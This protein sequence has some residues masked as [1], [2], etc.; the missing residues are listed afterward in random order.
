MKISGGAWNRSLRIVLATAGISL[1]SACQAIFTFSPLAFLQRNPENLPLEQ[2][3][4]YGRNA[5]AS[6]DLQTMRTAYDS[7]Q[8]IE[9]VDALY[10]S[11]E[12]AAELSGVP[13]I[14]LG[15]AG[16]SGDQLYL[17]EGNLSDL[18][19]YLSTF[20]ADPALLMEAADLFSSSLS[21]GQTLQPLDYLYGSLG[22][23]LTAAQQPDGSL[24]FST[25]TDPG[26]VA[27]LPDAIA[28][29][30]LGIAALPPQPANDPI[31]VF[32][33]TFSKYL[34]SL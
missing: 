22:L 24:D 3:I 12:L 30:D 17:T 6:G 11:A 10:V 26:F 34:Q 7:L 2:K 27:R 21:L 32:F 1:L 16:I 31:L 14:V 18:G 8:G 28:F 33:S 13:R 25:T 4:E 15:L 19:G 20:D 29:L 5:L 9:T 23:L